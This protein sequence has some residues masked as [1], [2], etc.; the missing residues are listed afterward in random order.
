MEVQLEQ[1]LRDSESE[2]DLAPRGLT[3]RSRRCAPNGGFRF[4]G[5]GLGVFS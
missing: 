1:E 4:K 5:L 3:A 2:S